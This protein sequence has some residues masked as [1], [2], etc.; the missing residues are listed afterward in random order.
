MSQLAHTDIVI[1]ALRKIFYIESNSL[2][3]F[4][5]PTSHK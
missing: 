5:V 3:R 4:P 2:L 1:I